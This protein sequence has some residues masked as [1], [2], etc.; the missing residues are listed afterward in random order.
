MS[1]QQVPVTT[2]DESRLLATALHAQVALYQSNRQIVNA[3]RIA[4]GLILKDIRDSGKW[5]YWGEHVTSFEQFCADALH[6][7]KSLAYAEI[8]VA[9]L[10]ASMVLERREFQDIE[11]SRFIALLPVARECDEKEREEWLYRALS[12]PPRGWKDALRE[13]RGLPTTDTCP[14]DGEFVIFR[15]CCQCGLFEKIEALEAPATVCQ[16]E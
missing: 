8:A 3:K 9:E 7:S 14:H 15:R 5:R 13:A 11:Y 10:F 4:N 16:E 1:V 2:K 12:L 6:I